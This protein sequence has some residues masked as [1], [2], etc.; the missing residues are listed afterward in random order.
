MA[1]NAKQILTRSLE[2]IEAGHW[3]QNN[4]EKKVYAD[5]VE[6][7]GEG[8]L[9]TV[10]CAVGLVSFYGG[11]YAE[12]GTTL[13]YPNEENAPTGVKKAIA[14]LYN[15]MPKTAQRVIE[16]SELDT[17]VTGGQTYAI[18]NRNDDETMTRRKAINWF[19]K[20]LESLS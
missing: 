12:D 8:D 17:D 11:V 3:C 9:R 5:G 6:W 14:A 20:A 10:H 16:E 18:W 15:A 19:R 4:L 7:S 1:R 2:E 13:D